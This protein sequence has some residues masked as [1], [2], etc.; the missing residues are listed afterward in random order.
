MVSETFDPIPISLFEHYVYCP[1]QC[2][3][4]HVEQAWDENLYA[5]P[6]DVGTFVPNL[7]LSVGIDR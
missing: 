4:I 2:P 1:H 5:M 6:G 3:L 7:V